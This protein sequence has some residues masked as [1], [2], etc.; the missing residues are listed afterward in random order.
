MLLLPKHPTRKG[1]LQMDIHEVVN[2]IGL[3]TGHQTKR[4]GH[5]YTARCP[6]HDDQTPS[7]S[8]GEGSDGKILLKGC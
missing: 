1:V 2:R 3:K 5:G 6:A 4:S 7:L 8:I